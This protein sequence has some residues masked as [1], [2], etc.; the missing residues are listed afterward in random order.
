LPPQVS[1]KAPRP[2]ALRPQGADWRVAATLKGLSD[3][4]AALRRAHPFTPRPLR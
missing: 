3:A 2:F 1:R 4:A